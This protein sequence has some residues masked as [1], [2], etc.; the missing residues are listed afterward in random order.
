MAIWLKYQI[1]P[2]TQSLKKQ[3]TFGSAAQV[4]FATPLLF[5]YFFFNKKE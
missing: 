4:A 1:D 3:W 5:Q 2:P